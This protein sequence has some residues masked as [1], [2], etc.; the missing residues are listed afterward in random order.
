MLQP[1]W[2]S[3]AADTLHRIGQPDHARA[4]YGIN[5]KEER[6]AARRRRDAA[7]RKTRPTS[8]LGRLKH[9]LLP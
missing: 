8:L 7:K 1:D 5:E 2:K 4:L 3:R 9:W 6:A